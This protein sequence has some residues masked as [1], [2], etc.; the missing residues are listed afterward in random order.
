MWKVLLSNGKLITETQTLNWLTLPKYPIYQLE[1]LLPNN[2]TLIMSGFEQYA[3]ICERYQFIKG[4]GIIKDTVNFLG[5]RIDLVYQ[6]SF[7]VRKMVA[8]QITNKNIDFSP[9]QWDT[10][11]KS[12]IFGKEQKINPSYW[13]EG[14][15][16]HQ[17]QVRIKDN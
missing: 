8:K 4:G 6:F 9:L 16:L 10:I 15:G 12:F 2:R 1:Y 14:L 11:T 3:Y 5:R 13:H 17:I 7:N